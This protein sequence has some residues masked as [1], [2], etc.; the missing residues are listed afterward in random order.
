MC[1]EKTCGVWQK[2]KQSGN[3][4]TVPGQLNYALDFTV[5]MVQSDPS[6]VAVQSMVC[7]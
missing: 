4:C 3:R 1:R 5:G 2:E 7:V 6:S